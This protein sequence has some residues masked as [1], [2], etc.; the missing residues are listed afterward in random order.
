MSHYT[1]TLTTEVRLERMR[2]E[3]VEIAKARQPAIYVAFGSIE[4]HGYHNPVGLATLKAHEQLVG[5]APRVGGRP[6]RR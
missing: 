6:D 2:P 4:W 1:D 3:E 5:L